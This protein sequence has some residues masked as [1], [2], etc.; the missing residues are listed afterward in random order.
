M[1]RNQIYLRT[2][3]TGPLSAIKDGSELSMGVYIGD[4]SFSNSFVTMTV[5]SV[6]PRTHRRG[7]ASS[8]L[9]GIK[10]SQILR[11]AISRVWFRFVR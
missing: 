8:Y 2:G 5:R 6:V 11:A 10:R 4:A 3:V 7:A 9:N 1:P